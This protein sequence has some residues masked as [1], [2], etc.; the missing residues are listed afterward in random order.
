MKH[1]LCNCSKMYIIYLGKF[2]YKSANNF[3][4]Y[5]EFELKTILSD[6]K[7][8]VTWSF[9]SVVSEIIKLQII[10]T[11]RSDR[12]VFHNRLFPRRIDK[13]LSSNT[14]CSCI[15]MNIRTLK[16]Y[17]KK[18]NENRSVFVLLN[19]NILVWIVNIFIS[20]H[21]M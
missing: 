2:V 19:Q 6:L 20:L 18:K 10:S 15:I 13:V 17:I 12:I 9:I 8:D 21:E 14:N 3:K 1:L 16:S 4:A 5:I 11:L 7:F